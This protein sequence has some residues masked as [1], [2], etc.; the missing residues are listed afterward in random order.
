MNH[1]KQKRTLTPAHYKFS[2]DAAGQNHGETI[3]KAVAIGAVLGLYLPLGKG[4]AEKP[5]FLDRNA[6]MQAKS[7]VQIEWVFCNGDVVHV[8]TFAGFRPQDRPT[9]FCYEC[10]KPVVLKLGNIVAHH[11]AHAA[12]P[13]SLSLSGG[14]SESVMHFNCKMRIYNQLKTGSVLYGEY[15][16]GRCQKVDFG[17]LCR[18]WTEV[19]IERRLNS[20]LIPDITLMRNGAVIMGIEVL[21]SHAVGA[22][23]AKVLAEQGIEWIEVVTTKTL[24]TEWSITQ[25]LPLRYHSLQHDMQ[26]E[27]CKENPILRKKETKD[28]EKVIAKEPATA[29]PVREGKVYPNR[30]CVVCGEEKITCST[31]S[32]PLCVKCYPERHIA[33]SFGLGWRGWMPTREA[34]LQ[35]MADNPSQTSEN[36]DTG[37]IS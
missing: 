21:A 34:A 17:E 8:S 30:S 36:E 32:G 33:D 18:N 37:A 28:Q 20:G 7:D 27:Q 6:S 12:S 29:Q 14:G 35:A 2:K 4:K 15:K 24:A 16:C 22:K 9:V 1:E 5:L 25:A 3:Q 19:R 10:R 31:S 23:K 26:C 13:C 11:A